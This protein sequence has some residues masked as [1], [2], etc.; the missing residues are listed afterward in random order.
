MSESRIT[1]HR[2]QRRHSVR[3]LLD[4]T[5]EALRRGA[6]PGAVVWPTGF[7][8]LDS[9]LNGGLRSGELVLLGGTEGSGKTTLAVQMIRNAVAAGRTAVIFSF[10]HEAQTVVQR[11]L[12]LEAAHA[13]EASDQPVSTAA[14]VHAFRSVFEAEDPH[15]AGLGEALGRL[16]YGRA[17]LSMMDAYA[18]R[19]HIHSSNSQTTIEEIAGTVA[20]IAEE[21]GEP[22]VVLV[23]YLQKVPRPGVQED[24]ITRVTIVT[25]SLKDLAMELQCPVVAITAADRD[26]LGSGH[27][28][29]TKDLRGSSALA[30]EADVVL[31]LSSKEHIVSREHLVYDLGAVKI[32]RRWSVITV[33]KN[34]HGTGSMELEVQKNFEHG[35]FYPKVRVVAERLIEERVFTT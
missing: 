25:E 9:T 6:R 29:R 31:I 34:R 23:D 35:R 33:E 21:A 13:A 14:D 8:L 19:L 12:G 16:A 4:D 11:L 24:E 27:R 18:E 7:D 3:H 17:A 10:E 2:P 32:Y 1:S 15:R 30:Y 20:Q 5:D 28:M 22:P 26:S